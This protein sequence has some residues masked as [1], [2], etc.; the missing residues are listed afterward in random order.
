VLYPQNICY[1]DARVE[2][3]LQSLIKHSTSRI[4]EFLYEENCP[5]IQALTETEKISL[6]LWAKVG[7]D[8]QGDHSEYMQ[9]NLQPVSGSSVYCLSYVPLLLKANGRLLWRNPEPNS[10]LICM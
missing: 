5:E 7:G 3:S 10:P 2:V 6:E 1:G 9:R 8:G 4:L